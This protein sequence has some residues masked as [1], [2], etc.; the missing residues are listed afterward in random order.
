MNEEE[1]LA[2]VHKERGS[3]SEQ[4]QA[5]LE[6]IDTGGV[7]TRKMDENLD[8][9]EQL[10]SSWTAKDEERAKIARDW[11]EQEQREA[12]EAAALAKT[13]AERARVADESR[14]AEEAVALEAEKQA[15]VDMHED[16]MAVEDRAVA[17][18][19]AELTR[20]REVVQARREAAEAKQKKR[21]NMGHAILLQ[22]KARVPELRAQRLAIKEGIR[23]QKLAQLGELQSRA[24]WAAGK[25]QAGFR[26]RQMRVKGARNR[27]AVI[28]ATG[29][30]G[31]AVCRHCLERGFEVVGMSRR[32]DS[33]RAEAL[34]RAGARIE[35]GDLDD[36]H[37][38][39]LASTRSCCHSSLHS[40]AVP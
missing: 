37:R 4:E 39:R 30:I 6:I 15:V 17:E 19:N 12:R 40:M 9:L 35:F 20:Q 33:D 2:T 29:Q 7:V 28:G 27:V 26:G 31:G 22:K 5:M 1:R 13:N 3:A 24:H 8:R 36:A 10:E 21:D 16:E 38:C 25:I 23:A 32:P 18:A 11:A 14:Q 34:R